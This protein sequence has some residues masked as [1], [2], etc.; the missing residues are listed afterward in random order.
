ML[1]LRTGNPKHSSLKLSFFLDDLLIQLAIQ[2]AV[3]FSILCLVDYR[4]IPT[5]WH[6]ISTVLC[7]QYSFPQLYP[8]DPTVETEQ[9]LVTDLKKS[10]QL[11]LKILVVEKV[12]RWYC[13]IVCTKCP[14]TCKKQ[15]VKDVT[16][17]IDQKE[18]FG[19]LGV[20]G[21]GKSSIFNILTGNLIPTYGSAYV[22]SHSVANCCKRHK[23]KHT[24]F[25]NRMIW[26]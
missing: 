26:I 9:A 6:K 17:S 18:C 14:C 5:I 7:C 10:R 25:F 11:S 16:F 8:K 3:L 20:N 24:N 22:K 13:S 21:A 23:V 15:A 19:L 1:L 2:I 4:I 12:K